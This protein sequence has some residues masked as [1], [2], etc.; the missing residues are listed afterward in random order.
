MQSAIYFDYT[1]DNVKYTTGKMRL[2][3]VFSAGNLVS[4]TSVSFRES[5]RT[6]IGGILLLIPLKTLT[7]KFS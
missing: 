3:N 5:K 7:H 2:N 4:L 1:Y 6:C